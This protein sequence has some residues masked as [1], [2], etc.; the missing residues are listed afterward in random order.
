M[1]D[2]AR[3][4]LVRE[5]VLAA[6]DEKVE[7]PP[8]VLY[9]ILE[10]LPQPVRNP[11]ASDRVASAVERLEKRERLTGVDRGDAMALCSALP[12]E[13]AEALAWVTRLDALYA[14]LLAR[15]DGAEGRAVV[16]I[17]RAIRLMQA[18]WDFERDSLMD[19][20]PE[21]KSDASPSSA[22][23]P[24]DRVMRDIRLARKESPSCDVLRRALRELRPTSVL[25]VSSV[26]IDA[27]DRLGAGRQIIALDAERLE[28]WCREAGLA[29]AG[30]AESPSSAGSASPTQQPAQRREGT[31]PK[32]LRDAP[33]G[34]KPLG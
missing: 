34:I 3:A 16:R 22:Q 26:V 12:D 13:R 2:A 7:F 8:A 28:A 31:R 1:L 4:L 15:A 33:F 32:R 17:A 25:I 10:A 30:R 27:H 24:L 21:R 6:L 18:G 29:P 23:R 5:A 20:P 9:S 14:T 11:A 19:P